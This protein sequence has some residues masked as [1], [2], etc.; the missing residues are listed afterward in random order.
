[1]RII[2]CIL[3][4]LICLLYLIS[5][6]KYNEGFNIIKYNIWMWWTNTKKYP[7]G[8]VGNILSVFFNS[9][10]FNYHIKNNPNYENN[11]D[12]SFEY[13]N[14]FINLFNSLKNTKFTRKQLELFPKQINYD[15]IWNIHKHKTKPYWDSIKR[16]VTKSLKGFTT[17]IKV[18]ELEKYPILHFRCSD[19]PFVQHNNYHFSKY[20]FYK[21]CNDKLKHKYKKWYIMWDNS[22]LSNNNYKQLS[23]IYFNDLKQYL[24]NDLNLEIIHINKNNQYEDFKLLYNAPVVIQGGCGGSFS[25]FG[26]YFNNRFLYTDVNRNEHENENNNY[27]DSHDFYKNGILTHNEVKKA[28]GYKNTSKVIKLLKS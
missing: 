2:I 17:E 24:E 10:I 21:W 5:L 3:I 6:I 8:G 27:I 1:M 4:L 7:S 26:G 23:S 16:E 18:T 25:F 14:H 15:S 22:H 28:G 19:V 20:N 11:I 13:R 12:S 9:M